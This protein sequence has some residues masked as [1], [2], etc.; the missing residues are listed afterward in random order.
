VNGWSLEAITVHETE[1]TPTVHDSIRSPS[2]KR[3][4]RIAENARAGAHFRCQHESGHGGALQLLRLLTHSCRLGERRCSSFD[5]AGRIGLPSE[6]SQLARTA[7]SC[8]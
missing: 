6:R 4:G 1:G 7:Q 5:C 3:H 2:I 8:P